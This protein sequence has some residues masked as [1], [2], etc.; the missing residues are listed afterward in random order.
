VKN[1]FLFLLFLCGCQVQ[2][3]S[4]QIDLPEPP[5]LKM[6]PIEWNVNG[7]DICLSPENYSNLSLNINDLKGFII[8]QN[9]VIKIYKYNNT[10]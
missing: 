7:G 3:E 5:E 6:R 4:T 1:K 8:Y 10:K 2:N 9:K